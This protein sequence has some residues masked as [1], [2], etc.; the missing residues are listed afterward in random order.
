[1][2]DGDSLAEP[3]VRNAEEGGAT[4]GREILEAADGRQYVGLPQYDI[5]VS[6]GGGAVIHSEQIVDILAFNRSWYERE[7]GIPVTQ[8]ALF[9][10]HGDSMVPDLHDGDLAVIDLGKNAFTS[11][12]IYVILEGDALRIKK[13]SVR[14]D[15]KIE[16]KSSNESYGVE[17]LTPEQA[18]Q[19][20]VVGRAKRAFPRMRR[21]P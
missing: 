2:Y 10:V 12:A 1:M 3:A 8:V 9:E 6:A 4:D 7:I 16:I 18:E 17:T 14:V 13:V 19:I 21:L 15:G 20:V 11:N 5:R